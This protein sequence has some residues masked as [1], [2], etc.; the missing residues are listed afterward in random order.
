MSRDM[1]IASTSCSVSTV[2]F[3]ILISLNKSLSVVAADFESARIVGIVRERLV[4]SPGKVVLDKRLAVFVAVCTT[5]LKLLNRE[6]RL[7][8]SSCMR[9]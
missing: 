5:N 8:T 4:R 2:S 3:N 6:R 1:L 9:V 7:W